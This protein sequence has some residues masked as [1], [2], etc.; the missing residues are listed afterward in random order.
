M[1]RFSFYIL[2]INYIPTLDI[3][4]PSKVQSNVDHHINWLTQFE[5]SFQLIQI[6]LF[7][8][9]IASSNLKD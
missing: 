3:S 2:N 9:K 7:N 6:L 5:Q 8:K 1:L 4:F